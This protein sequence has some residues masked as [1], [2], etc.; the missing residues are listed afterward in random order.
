MKDSLK[1]VYITAPSVEVAKSLGRNLLEKRLAACINIL[2]QMSSLYWWEGNIET[3]EE[4]VLI[5]KT[6]EILLRDLISE[7]EKQ[8]PYTVPCA[9]TINIESGSEGYLKWLKSCLQPSVQQFP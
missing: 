2:P 1:L 6:D 3:S 5:A 7:V 4:V 9:L 8:H